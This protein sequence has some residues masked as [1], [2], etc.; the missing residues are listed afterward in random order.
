MKVRVKKKKLKSQRGW[1]I[2]RYRRLVREISAATQDRRFGTDFAS[3]LS[4]MRGP[5]TASGLSLEQYLRIAQE[6]KA[7]TTLPIRYALNWRCGGML[8]GKPAVDWLAA[9][10]QFDSPHFTSHISAA[11]HALKIFGYSLNA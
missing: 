8:P 6:V 2:E 10:K 5:D 3:L 11:V 7:Y 4:A 9:A 1:T